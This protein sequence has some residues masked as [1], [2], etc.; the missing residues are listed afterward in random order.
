MRPAGRIVVMGVAGSGKSTIAAALAADWQLPY[1][2]ADSLHSEANIAKMASGIPLTDADRWSWLA[3]VRRAMRREPEAVIACS[4]L[5]RSYR[6]ALRSAGDVRFLDLVVDRAEVVRR[7]AERRAHFMEAE[8][9]GSQF[10]ALEPPAREETDVAPIDAS[11]DR[12]SVVDRA[13]AA[14]AV[15]RAGTAIRPLRSLG[16]PERAISGDELREIVEGLA[17][18]Q[19]LGAGARRVLLVPPDLTRLHSRAGEITGLLFERLSTAGCEV[20]VLPALGTHAALTPREAKLLF[21]DLVPFERILKHRWREALVRVGEISGDEIS[22]LSGG[23][24]A[25]PIPVEVNELLLDGWDLVVSIGQVVPHE[26]IGMANFTKNLVIGLGGGLTIHRSH[27]LGAVCDM[28]TIMGCAH[29]PVR[30][31]VD[32]AFDRF[33]AARVPVLWVLTV[34]EDTPEGVVHRG[35]FV[36]RGG[37]GE[38]GG[39]AYEAAAELSARCNIELVVEPLARVTCWLDPD[40]FRTTWVANKAIYRTRMAL[41]DGGELVV[42]A[43]AVSR[44]GEDP[45][46][47]ALIRRHGYR[48]TPAALDAMRRD[49]ELAANLGAVAHLIHG[50][51]EG[52]FRIVYCTDPAAG[53]LTR[54]EVEGVGYAWR[55]LPEELD[56]LG[57]TSSTPTGERTDRDGAPFTHIANAA[58]GLWTSRPT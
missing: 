57:V 32:A 11:G 18:N 47:D 10:E 55:P 24:M 12:A 14:L 39:A 20:A 25:E 7:V 54:E 56:R 5:K 23:L 34:T 46:I 29:G 52:R 27:F 42:L 44:F 19:I 48:G 36:G 31:V 21:G 49:P 3:A 8:M 22:A 58:L 38:S 28:E 26:V 15:L 33:L 30:D 6:D 1:I 17:T 4:A 2:E 41:A 45:A 13:E 53:G 43:P 16:G 51:S 50:S 35:V 37:S 40:E 9:V